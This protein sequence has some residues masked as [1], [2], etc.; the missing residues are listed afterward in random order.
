FDSPELSDDGRHRGRHD[1]LVEAGEEHTG[2]EGAEDD[3]DPALGEEHG[4]L[5]GGRHERAFQSA[6][7]ARTTR[8][9][10][11]WFRRMVGKSWVPTGSRY[12]SPACLSRVVR[13]PTT[14]SAR[15]SSSAT[16]SRDA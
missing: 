4:P 8:S 3:P 13:T 9:A 11:R 5:G 1:R 7:G 12:C 10:A 2:D 6:G 15:G 14:A 16:F